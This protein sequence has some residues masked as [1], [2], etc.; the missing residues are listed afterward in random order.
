M[1][2]V[3][4]NCIWDAILILLY[5]SCIEVLEE[6]GSESIGRFPAAEDRGLQPDLLYTAQLQFEHVK[7]DVRD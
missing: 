1:D 6:A 7:T 2:S 5:L 4:N 3:Y